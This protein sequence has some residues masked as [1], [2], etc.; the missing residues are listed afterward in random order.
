MISF[1]LLLICLLVKTEE[2]GKGQGGE[3]GSKSALVLFKIFLL[4]QRLLII[5]LVGLKFE[6]YCML[7]KNFHFFQK[8]TSTQ[9]STSFFSQRNTKLR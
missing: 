7:Q 2:G 4:N 3:E 9:K 5:S 6:F 8:L 1:F